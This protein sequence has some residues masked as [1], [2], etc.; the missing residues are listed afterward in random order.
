M[1]TLPIHFW[2]GEIRAVEFYLV[3][4][5]VMD[6]DDLLRAIGKPSGVTLKAPSFEGE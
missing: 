2:Y 5:K 1:Q 3:V 6:C 4:T